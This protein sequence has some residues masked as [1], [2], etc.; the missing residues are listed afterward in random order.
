MGAGKN[1]LIATIMV[2]FVC[3]LA[4]A[5]SPVMQSP[6]NGHWYQRFDDS[7][8]WH[9]AVAYCESLGGHLA[10][11]T[12]QA[13]K[14]FVYNNLASVSPQ[15]CWLGATD[16][17][18]EG[19]WQWVTGEPWVYSAWQRGEPNNCGGFEN[20]LMFFT[21]PDPRAGRWNDLGT[22]NDGGCGC[23]GCINEYYQ[24]STI[25][26]WSSMPG[27]V[28]MHV[29]KFTINLQNG[30]FKVRGFL[31][32][33]DPALENLIFDPQSIIQIKLQTGGDEAAPEFGIV[34][35]EQIQ[36]RTDRNWRNLRLEPEKSH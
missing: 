18:N 10:T 36:L 35:E 6:D 33:A 17:V 23:G 16:E 8:S 28:D 11:I 22:G 12:S 34:A 24:M 29:T 13:E 4:Y 14:D 2:V 20:Y 30:M 9:Q 3:G 7:M 15:W 5:D 32:I 19:V 26:E 1:I 31:D 25:C 21:P 27:A